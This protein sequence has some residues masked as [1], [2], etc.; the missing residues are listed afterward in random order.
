MLQSCM[1][2]KRMRKF[3]LIW[4]AMRDPQHTCLALYRELALQR[5]L[6]SVSARVPQARCSCTGWS[7]RCAKIRSLNPISI[8]SRCY[9]SDANGSR[10]DASECR[11]DMRSSFRDFATLYARG[12]VRN[13]ATVSSRFSPIAA[14]D[15][16]VKAPPACRLAAAG[17]LSLHARRLLRDLGSPLGNRRRIGPTTVLR[18]L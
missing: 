7:A 8:Q 3:V 5:L 9:R 6:Q 2:P 14:S 15:A 11:V 16:T 4:R 12:K 17:T 1:P 10:G 18:V 13:R